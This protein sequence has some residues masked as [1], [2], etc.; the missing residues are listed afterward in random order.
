MYCQCLTTSLKAVELFW[1]R[2]VCMRVDVFSF[3]S[4]SISFWCLY[5]ANVQAGFAMLRHPEGLRREREGKQTLLIRSIVWVLKL[6]VQNLN[7]GSECCDT[8]TTN[9][10]TWK[11]RVIFICMALHEDSQP[12]NWSTVEQECLMNVT[13]ASRVFSIASETWDLRRNL[14]IKIWQSVTVFRWEITEF[15]MF[16]VETCSRPPVTFLQQ[17]LCNSPRR[18]SLNLSLTCGTASCALY[19]CLWLQE[20]S[21]KLGNINV[22]WLGKIRDLCFLYSWKIPME[23][24]KFCLL[25]V[26]GDLIVLV[27]WIPK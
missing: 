14:G 23:D 11:V 9:T 8:W 21:V 12:S 2:H 17:V 6:T 5:V 7:K 3:P 15:A 24:H 25:L 19:S 26:S 22:R 1:P 18:S 4:H 13:R 27:L 20:Y 16:W 10:W